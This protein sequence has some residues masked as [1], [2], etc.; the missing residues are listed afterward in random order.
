MK[1]LLALFIFTI[2]LFAV[3]NGELSFYILKDQKALAGQE[4]VVFVKKENKLLRHKSM[5]TDSDGFASATLKEG[6]YQLQVVAKDKKT[7]LVF[8]RKNFIIKPNKES[9]VIIVLDSK[10]NLLFTDIE[11]PQRSKSIKK[12]SQEKVK[13]GTLR[14]SLISSE[15]K[16]PVKNARVFVK[17]MDIDIKS[18]EKGLVV[19][20]V[21][22]GE[23]TL[24]V[25]HND[26]S[27]Q[28]IAV[29]VAVNETTLKTVELSPASME[30]DEFVVLAPQIEGSVAAV[31][32]EEKNS[33]SIANIVGSEQ[34]SKQGDSNAASALK[35]VAGITLIGGKYVYVRGLGD[36][37]SSTELNGMSLPS[38]NPVKRT[39][40]LDM[41]PSGI[42]G[43]LQVQKSFSSD[44]TG[45]FGGGY[46]NIRTKQGRD[47][48]YAKIKLGIESHSTTGKDVVGYKGSSSDWSGYDSSY[49]PFS[50]ELLS[51]MATV[52]GENRPKISDISD[53]DMQSFTTKREYNRVNKSVPY[54]NNIGFEISKN[55]TLNDEHEINILANYGYKTTSEA[56]EYTSY[57]YLISSEGT[58]TPEPDNTAINDIFKT[59]IQHGGML[60]LSYKYKNF[61]AKYTKLYVLNTLE[62]TRDIIGTFGENNSDEHQN[63]FEWQERELNIDQVN[64]GLD[65]KLYLENR[66]EFGFEFAKAN[67]YVPNDVFY[68]YKKLTSSTPYVFARNQSE[69]SFSNRNTD[70][71]V[72]STYIKNKTTVPILSDED[73]VELGAVVEKKDR[74]GRVNTLKIQSKI[75]DEDLIAGDIDDILS[76]DDPSKLD[77]SL[78]SR[79]KDNYNAS[80]KRSAIYLKSMINP[81]DD[82]FIILGVRRESLLQEADQFSIENNMVETDKNTLK[83]NKTLPSL[84]IKYSIDD[85]S[86]IKFAYGQTFIYPDFREFIDAEFI[87]P[88]FVAK[89]AGNPDLVETDIS[90]YDLQYG[91]YFND[92]DNVTASIFYKDMKNPIE[93]VRTFTTSTLD[94]F[95]FENSD[96]A[97]ISGIE[98]SWYKN[99]GFLSG[100]LKDIV[101]SGNYTRIDSKV[102]LTDE[103][104][105]KYVTQSRGLQGLSPEVI[106]LS[107]TYQNDER[108]LN[109]SY[110]KMAERL[111]RVALKNGT[112]ILGL[113]EYEIP[114]QLLDFTWIEKFRSDV[115]NSDMSLIFKVKNLLDSETTWRQEDLTT[116]KYKTGQSYSLSLSAKF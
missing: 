96:S 111:M 84:S 73:Y 29:H 60:N 92:I 15:T 112:V 4:V 69:I 115:L 116:L 37:Y 114:P 110:N 20:D 106:N 43:T 65:Y 58:Q 94:R 31:M 63:Y 99:L 14:L 86:Q 90:S 42:I 64:G 100:Y 76:Y 85:S 62:Q 18:D 88:E 7:P 74:V 49:R 102:T 93:D 78:T 66:V 48:D 35:R 109:L 57:D 82:L 30:L 50:G 75:R 27:S 61:D 83:F 59:N 6:E 67:E 33:N 11:A 46:V 13:N 1:K 19:V 2:S 39:V 81:N 9:Q 25:I 103:Q 80:L 21:P 95:S 98:F 22:S 113:D 44:I 55:I 54:G 56:R 17:G 34:M 101:F 108:S 104:K 41:F 70:D 40:P 53:E 16:K 68:N 105:I 12:E 51:Q 38:P 89:I 28:N 79:P 91:Y 77:Y 32:A 10:D 5:I 45:A 72:F 23:R 26:F 52:V 97:T 47:E 8:A 107:L 24:S 87:H 36:R 71:D 3:Q